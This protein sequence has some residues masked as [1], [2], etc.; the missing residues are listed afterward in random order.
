MIEL[1][2]KSKRNTHVT[3]LTVTKQFLKGSLPLA[4]YMFDDVM[5]GTF[6]KGLSVET[7]FLKYSRPS[8]SDFVLGLDD[9]NRAL[10]SLNLDWGGNLPRIAEFFNSLDLA[11][12]QG[13]LRYVSTTDIGEAIFLN[14]SKNVDD[15]ISEHISAVHKALKEKNMLGRLRD[16]F[17]FINSQRDETCEINEFK[18][19]IKEIVENGSSIPLLNEHKY[20]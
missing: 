15:I 5:I 2:A 12:H 6:Q 10:Q 16:L 4:S 11:A 7:H 9:F 14:A 8:S 1:P 13:Q 18:R 3:A 20:D 17:N 19:V